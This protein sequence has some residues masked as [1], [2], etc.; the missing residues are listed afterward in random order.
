MAVLLNRIYTKTGDQGF[1]RLVG[2]VKISKTSLRLEGYGTVDELNSFIGLIRTHALYLSE[3]FS[4]VAQ[5]TKENFRLIQNELFDIGSIMATPH[6]SKFDG[7][8]QIKPD[9]VSRLEKQIDEYQTILENLKSFTLPG[10][11]KLNAYA[12]VARTVCRRLERLL[13]RL[14][15]EEPLDENI[16]KYVN[17][18]SDYLFVYSRWVAKQLK[19]D[20]FLWE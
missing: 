15:E 6:G 20:E 8:H 9:Q 5:N 10:G 1:T 19:E 3:E 16:M 17:R 4:D 7:R 18:L 2:G 14:N 11:G 13:W 12:H